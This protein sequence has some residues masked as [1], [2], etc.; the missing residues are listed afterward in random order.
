METKFEGTWG[1][2]FVASFLA[3][4]IFLVPFVGFA[5]GYV[6]Y[7]KYMVGHTVVGGKK[8]EFNCTWGKAW[9]SLFVTALLCWLPGL[10]MYRIEKLKWDNTVVIG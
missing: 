6:H 4:L 1:G 8:L 9:V 10:A 3:G 5:I 2:V 7:M